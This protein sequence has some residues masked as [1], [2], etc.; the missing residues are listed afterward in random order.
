VAQL[1]DRLASLAPRPQAGIARRL[2]HDALRLRAL[3]RS[4]EAVS[5]LATVARGY[6]IV[7]HDSG[8]VVRSVLDTAPGDAL[9]AR[10][11]DGWLKLRVEGSRPE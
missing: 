6:A 3:A 11:T 5:P 7:R 9:E 4:L 2:G 8:R 10:V 1:R